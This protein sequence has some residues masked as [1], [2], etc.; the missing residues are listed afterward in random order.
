MTEAEA[1]RWCACL[2][3]EVLPY[4]HHG[5]TLYAVKVKG[6]WPATAERLEDA[7]E[8]LRGNVDPF[9]DNG[10]THGNTGTKLDRLRVG[11]EHFL[12]SQLSDERRRPDAA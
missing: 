2:G 10:A 9:L 6:F 4:T 8:A 5:R 12:S 11:R 1:R 3:A 7:V